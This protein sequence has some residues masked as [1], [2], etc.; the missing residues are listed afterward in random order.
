MQRI[1][2]VCRHQLRPNAFHTVD[3]ISVCIC[4]NWCHQY[5]LG[6]SGKHRHHRIVHECR[7]IDL[8]DRLLRH[9]CNQQNVRDSCKLKS[10]RKLICRSTLGS[11]FEEHTFALKWMV[12]GILKP[13]FLL[14]TWS[15]FVT[16]DS[17]CIVTTVTSQDARW[18]G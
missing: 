8:D 14:E 12:S 3:S 4:Y 9:I 16:M 11:L 6:N 18:T 7:A 17:G 13:F 10:E 2:Y 1:A 15:T 5:C